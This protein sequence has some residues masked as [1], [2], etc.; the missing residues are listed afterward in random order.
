[1]ARQKKAREIKFSVKFKVGDKVRVKQ[2]TL[3]VD[4][5]D[6]PMGG[7]VGT[8]TEISGGDTFTIRWSK[9]TLAAIHPVFKKRCEKDGLDLEEYALTGDD[10]EPDPGGPLEIE[11]PTSITTKPLSPKD[12]D[13]RV[14][15][16]FGLTS[17][18]PLPQV[19]EETLETYRNYLVSHLSF[20]F[21]AKRTPEKGMFPRSTLVKV[22]GLGDPD[23]EP[24]YVDDMYGLLCDALTDKRRVVVPVGELEVPK[25]KPNRQLIQD[26]C[27]WFWNYG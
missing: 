20:P 3:D 2:G 4:Y 24:P 27:Y 6:M 9:D 17:N 7:W 15:M 10:L 8:V 12:E 21:E 19:D 16:V 18:D 13:D 23:E 11:Q 26:Y 1:M 14:R 22:T 25:G 5:P